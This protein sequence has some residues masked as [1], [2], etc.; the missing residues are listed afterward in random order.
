MKQVRT[1]VFETNSSSTHSVCICTTR[2]GITFPERIKFRCEYFSREDSVLR[3]IEDKAA[4][5][6]AS[7]FS[8]FYG[9]RKSFTDAVNKIF[10]HLGAHGIECE[11]E[12]PVESEY[13]YIDFGVEHSGNSDHADFV[14]KTVGNKTRLIRYLF[15]PQSYVITGSDEA[16]SDITIREPY[17]HEE[18]YKWN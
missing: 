10:T 2:S 13:G 17:R 5:L 4:Y 3:T 6:Y 11:F 16:D 18:Y 1:G 15:N 8:L 12:T 9:D 7:I 14:K